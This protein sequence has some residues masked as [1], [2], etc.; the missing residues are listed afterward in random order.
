MF[1]SKLWAA[2]AQIFQPLS[3]GN[4]IEKYIISRN[5][6]TPVDVEKF[7]EEWIRSHNKGWI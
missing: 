2:I 7:T 4:S 3:Y 6:K 1:I 5:P